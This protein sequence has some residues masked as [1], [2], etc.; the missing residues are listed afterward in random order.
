[1]NSD[2][3]HDDMLPLG[4]FERIG[5]RMR[6]FK[7]K[8]KAP[9]AP[10]YEKLAQQTA[11]LDLRNTRAQT[12]SNRPNQINPYGTHTWQQ[13]PNNQDMWTETT[14]LSKPGQDI[15][16]QSNALSIDALNNAKINGAALP[17]R[18]VNAGETMTDALMRRLQP[19]LDTQREAL[20]TQLANQGISLGSEA[21]DTSYRNQ[22]QREN[23]L[24]TSAQIQGIQAG[25]ASRESALQEQIL[26]KNQPINMVNAI[27][28]GSQITNPNFGSAP[29]AGKGASPD[30]MGAANAGYQGKL[31][32]YNAQPDYMQGL[33]GLGGTIL[34]APGGSAG[35]ALGGAIGSGIG[36]IGNWLG[37]GS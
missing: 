17:A 26:R 20:R 27:R 23:D 21:Y 34:G 35:A 4:A 5:G 6:L 19:Q 28:S 32:A 37:I 29:M 25:D 36:K 31:N 7:G 13:D 3:L 11:D 22:N 18:M 15:L 2:Y 1:M 30:L 12:V 9:K 10:N 33:F 8:G 16:D 24:L 14:T